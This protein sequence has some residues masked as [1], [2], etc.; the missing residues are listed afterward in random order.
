M[1]NKQ[2]YTGPEVA[3]LLGISR[4]AVFKQIKQGK[5]KASKIGRNYIIERKDIES[6]ISKSLDPKM[7]K[8][9]DQAVKKTVKDYKETLEL[10]GNEGR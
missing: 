2:Y 7:K 3:K 6:L 10:L 9:I 1:K 8:K 4:I 5:I